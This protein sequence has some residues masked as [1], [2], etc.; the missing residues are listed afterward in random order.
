MYAYVWVGMCIIYV[1]VCMCTFVYVCMCAYVY[2][3]MCA[4]VY[5]FMCAY[6]CICVCVYVCICVCVH[7]LYVRMCAYVYVH[8]LGCVRKCVDFCVFADLYIK[9][10]VQFTVLLKNLKAAQIEMALR[11]VTHQMQKSLKSKLIR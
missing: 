9:P 4:Y 6:V 5:E 1:Y 7:M 3:H 2:V 11:I 10:W 8:M